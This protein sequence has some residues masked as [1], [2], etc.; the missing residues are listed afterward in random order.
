MKTRDWHFVSDSLVSEVLTSLLAPVSY[1]MDQSQ[2]VASLAVSD[3]GLFLVVHRLVI[4]HVL[5]ANL[6][7]Y[8]P[9]AFR[10]LTSSLMAVVSSVMQTLLI[11]RDDL[12]GGLYQVCDG[13]CTKIIANIWGFEKT[14]TWGRCRSL[15]GY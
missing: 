4:P 13:K 8:I 9:L 11:L 7:K 1:A 3:V 15:L 14:W 2:C 5:T 12:H 6:W 10:G